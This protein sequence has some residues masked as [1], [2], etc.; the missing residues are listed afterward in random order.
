[1][2]GI[3]WTLGVTCCWSDDVEPTGTRVHITLCI[4]GGIHA[5]QTEVLLTYYKYETGND[6]Y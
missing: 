5:T 3:Y 6:Q 4:F 1:M 2:D